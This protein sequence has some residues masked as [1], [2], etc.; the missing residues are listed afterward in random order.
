ML[1]CSQQI[2]S[3]IFAY[4]KHI[5]PRYAIIVNQQKGVAT[6]FCLSVHAGT[7]R[8]PNRTTLPEC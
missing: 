8:V 3:K 4:M 5:R 7:R 6:I 2:Y 1:T